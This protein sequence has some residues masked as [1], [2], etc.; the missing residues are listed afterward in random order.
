MQSYSQTIGPMVRGSKNSELETERCALPAQDW[1][2]GIKNKQCHQNPMFKWHWLWIRS[3][4]ADVMRDLL[5]HSRMSFGYTG[6]GCNGGRRFCIHSGAGRTGL[7]NEPAWM[8]HSQS[9]SPVVC[10]QDTWWRRWRGPLPISIQVTH[11]HDSPPPVCWGSTGNLT[12]SEWEALVWDHWGMVSEWHSSPPEQLQSLDLSPPQWHLHTTVNP[13][14]GWCCLLD[15]RHWS[16]SYGTES[17]TLW[18]CHRSLRYHHSSCE[19]NMVC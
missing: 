17:W 8:C 7:W 15:K 9:L 13:L 16:W 14:V 2:M 12:C 5:E 1:E 18:L 6:W 3:G 10:Q 4:T 19:W 11:F